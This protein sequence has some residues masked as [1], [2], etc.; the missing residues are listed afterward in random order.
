MPD[1]RRWES[2]VRYSAKCLIPKAGFLP[3]ELPSGIPNFYN[4]QT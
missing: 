3:T 2:Q 4:P 1:G